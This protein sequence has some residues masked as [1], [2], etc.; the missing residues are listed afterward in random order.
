M[1]SDYFILSKILRK[2]DHIFLAGKFEKIVHFT[3]SSM[4]QKVC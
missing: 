4:Y 2:N 1:F 3:K